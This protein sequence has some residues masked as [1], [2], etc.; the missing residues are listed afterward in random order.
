METIN[1]YDKRYQKLSSNKFMACGYFSLLTAYNFHN[2]LKTTKTAYNKNLDDAINLSI[3]KLEQNLLAM[4]ELIKFTNE[5]K[6]SNLMGALTHTIK[7]IGIEHIFDN[8]NINHSYI[9]LKNGRFF[10]IL[11]KKSKGYF[12]R[13]SHETYQYNNL[14]LTQLKQILYEKYQFDKIIDIDGYLISEFSSIEY[15]KFTKPFTLNISLPENDIIIK[16]NNDFVFNISK[17]NNDKYPSI[18]DLTPY[19]NMKPIKRFKDPEILNCSNNNSSIASDYSLTKNIDKIFSSNIKF[20]ESKV[21]KHNI[22][23]KLKPSKIYDDTDY[24]NNS[25]ID[26]IINTS[27]DETDEEEDDTDEDVW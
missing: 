14:T 3:N 11:F 21:F 17:I 7:E 18:D 16:N 12:I 4:D 2:N 10:N 5:I 25:D 15:V 9:F 22:P 19:S 26:E 27:D 20:G 13:D 6:S 1:Q 8:E 23:I 24:Y